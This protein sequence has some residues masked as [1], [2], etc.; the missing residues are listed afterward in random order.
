VRLA[1]GDLEALFRRTL[2][3]VRQVT[4]EEGG[5]IRPLRI[6]IVT[7]GAGD[8]TESLAGR[9][10]V[11]DRPL[12]RFLILNGLDRGAAVKPGDRYKIVVE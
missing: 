9:M 4:P 3:T 10:V 12:E 2:A 7:A 8:T 11:S 6:E 1:N 5:A